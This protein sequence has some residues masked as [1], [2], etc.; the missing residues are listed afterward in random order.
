MQS[1]AVHV[2]IVEE[3]RR[4][5]KLR[6][7]GFPAERDWRDYSDVSCLIS[8]DGYQADYIRFRL[9][10]ARCQDVKDT[11]S[12]LTVTSR[13]LKCYVRSRERPK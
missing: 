13:P 7:E 11:S 12:S 8:R 6:L 10:K 5:V 1:R 3:L 2:Q 4:E 9:A